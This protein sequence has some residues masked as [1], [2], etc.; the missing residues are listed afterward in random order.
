M[1]KI[2]ELIDPQVINNMI[3][4]DTV[5]ELVTSSTVNSKVTSSTVNSKVTVSTID[6]LVKSST[7]RATINSL[8][9]N[10]TLIAGAREIGSYVLAQYRGGTYF[11]S[12]A[13]GAVVNGQNLTEASTSGG[14][15]VNSVGD[16]T[17]SG[18]WRLMGI[19]RGAEGEGAE[20]SSSNTSLFLRIS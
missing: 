7:V 11:D 9:E 14:K 10:D 12:L 2:S 6:N 18:M 4:G 5:N 16:G 8:I 1:S 13:L 19:V 3:L 15:G 17:L 20:I